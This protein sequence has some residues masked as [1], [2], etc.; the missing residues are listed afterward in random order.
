MS[1]ILVGRVGNIPVTNEPD[2]LAEAEVFRRN[3]THTG[4]K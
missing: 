3:G 4:G 2:V 1:A